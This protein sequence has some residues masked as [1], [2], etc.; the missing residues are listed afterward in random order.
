MSDYVYVGRPKESLPTGA[1]SIPRDRCVP[2]PGSVE[3]DL[4]IAAQAEEW[5]AMQAR[6]VATLEANAKIQRKPNPMRESGVRPVIEPPP[7]HWQDEPS[8]AD[9]DWR[10]EP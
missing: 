6:I 2:R 9:E 3:K 8:D 7:V 4:E 1:E 5:A 10:G